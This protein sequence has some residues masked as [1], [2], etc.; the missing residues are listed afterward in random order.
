MARKKSSSSTE[1]PS[2]EEALEELQ[3]IVDQLDE[4]Q[5]P[6]NDALQGFER[7]IHLYRVCSEILENAE[8]KVEM[9]KSQ[10]KGSGPEAIPVDSIIK[11][12]IDSSV[13][14]APPMSSDRTEATLSRVPAT[15]PEAPFDADPGRGTEQLYSE[16][17][18]R[19]EDNSPRP[20]A[21]L[22]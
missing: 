19:S 7:G 2:F 3:G 9:L 14:K 15:E 11:S 6:L 16:D 21:G 1:G 22:F 18:M 4:G 10:L 8:S 12:T 5:L 13:E 17:S 20:N